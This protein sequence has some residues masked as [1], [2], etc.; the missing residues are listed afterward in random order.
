MDPALEG[1]WI[2]LDT[3]P[4]AY[5]RLDNDFRFT[6]VNRAALSLFGKMPAELL[7]KKL[8]DVYPSS[9][10]TPLDLGCRRAMAERI[11]VTTQHCFTPQAWHSV[12]VMPDSRGGIC[13][14]FSEINEHKLMEEP[15]QKSEE[16]LYK[17]F[18]CSPSPMCVANM[19]TDCI[20]DVNEAFER[21]SGYRRTKSL[22]EPRMNTFVFATLLM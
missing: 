10:G 15:L 20:L 7:G 22:G 9:V 3:I 14:K 13:L 1:P 11:V 19:D 6:F 12:V 2:V 4:E 21:I 17:V 8:W 16:E 5:V 18:R